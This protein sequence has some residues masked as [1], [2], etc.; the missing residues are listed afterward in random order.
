[1]VD[2]QRTF[3]TLKNPLQREILKR[4]LAFI[5]T[6]LI[7]LVDNLYG[8]GHADKQVVANDELLHRRETDT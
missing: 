1:M 5:R 8:I 2:T 6:R 4:K 3:D 7:Q